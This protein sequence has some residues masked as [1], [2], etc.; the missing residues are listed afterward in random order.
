[1]G[2]ATAIDGKINTKF[3]DPIQVTIHDKDK[4]YV[5]YM[6]RPKYETNDAVGV[7][8]RQAIDESYLINYVYNGLEEG[9][10]KNVGEAVKNDN[11]KKT[12]VT[13]KD[14]KPVITENK[15]VSKGDDIFKAY[16]GLIDGRIIEAK[17]AK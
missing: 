10:I 2:V 9:E 8:K 7:A 6:Q 14:G 16:E 15:V 3:A 12:Y 13:K 1:M 11:L 17:K 5:L 4:D